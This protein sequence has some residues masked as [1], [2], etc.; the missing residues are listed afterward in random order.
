MA[1]SLRESAMTDGNRPLTVA[2]DL[3]QIDNQSLGSGQYRYAVDLVNGLAASGEELQL[4]LYGQHEEPREEFLPAMS[5][6]RRC[7]YRRLRPSS[8]R[9][10]FYYDIL[11][12]SYAL[13]HDRVDVFH[14]LHTSIPFFKLCPVVVTGYH[15]YYDPQLFVS[16]PNRYYRW[17]LKH[18]SDLVLTISDA[19]R[20]DFHEHYALSQDRMRTVHLGLSSSL[21]SAVGVSPMR[22]W[23]RYVLSPY[24]LSVPK[25]L[26][27]LLHAWPAIAD[28]FPEL[29]LVLYGRSQVNDANEAEFERLLTG[30]PHHDRV[31][32]LGYVDDTELAGL[33]RDCELF[34]F[35]TTVEGFGYPLLEAMAHGACCIARNASAMKEVGGD[36]VRLVETLNPGEIAGAA[37]PLLHDPDRMH[38]FGEL[39]R[40]RAAGF[41]IEAMVSRTL[42]SYRSLL[43]AAK[44]TPG[45]K[46]FAMARE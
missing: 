11:K 43:P 30:L 10:S 39:A 32:R 2:L 41:T 21:S 37:I 13:A 31:H 3:S 42:E 5:D 20:A 12:L 14:Q 17:A 4:V 26:V 45:R 8:G 44:A 19:T 28:Q 23:P 15:Y 18:R 34:V 22:R 40:Q 25:N 33:F 46:C 38:R 9:G 24:N 29:H 27:S 16:R 36:A 1:G 7:R 6:A 35:P